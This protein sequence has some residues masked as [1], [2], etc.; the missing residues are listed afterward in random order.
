MSLGGVSK[1]AMDLVMLVDNL[2]CFVPDSEAEGLQLAAFALDPRMIRAM[3]PWR[4]PRS[5]ITRT[6][7]FSPFECR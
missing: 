7:Q 1:K 2:S 3:L 5:R 4:M 6:V